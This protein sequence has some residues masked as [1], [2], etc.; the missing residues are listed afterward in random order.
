SSAI[1]KFD[2]PVQI[3]VTNSSGNEIKMISGRRW[4]NSG[5]SLIENNNNDYSQFRIF[6]LQNTGNVNVEMKD[7]QANT[8]R[9]SLYLDGF[10]DSFSKL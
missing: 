2:E 8:Y 7:S 1:E 10:S 4:N 3:K 9:F 6:L 5:G